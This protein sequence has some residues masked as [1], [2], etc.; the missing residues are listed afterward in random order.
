MGRGRD[1]NIRG[2]RRGEGRIGGEGVGREEEGEM[3]R[4]RNMVAGGGMWTKLSF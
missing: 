4:G 1:E 3:G 2:G